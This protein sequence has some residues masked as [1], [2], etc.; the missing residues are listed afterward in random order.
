M[1]RTCPR[2]AIGSGKGP[3][4]AP[5]GAQTGISKSHAR[6]PRRDQG[7]DLISIARP[8]VDAARATGLPGPQHPTARVILER[9]LVSRQDAKT[10]SFSTR[11]LGRTANPPDGG[12][13]ACKVLFFFAFLASLREQFPIPGLSTRTR[14]MNLS[15]QGVYEH[16][17][18]ESVLHE[19]PAD[20]LRELPGELIVAVAM[21]IKA[22][23]MPERANGAGRDRVS[24][25]A[26]GGAP[27]QRCRTS[28]GAVGRAH[29]DVGDC[30]RL[31]WE[32]AGKA[33]AHPIPP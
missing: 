32:P 3:E 6:M 24:D 28:P 18:A 33:A 31:L 19:L 11:D 7:P 14:L 26:G 27:P 13:I 10:Q 15:R 16:P 4:P 17:L 8:M 2:S 22:C 30:D 1:A 12:I 29:V 21:A 5:A 23:A 20:W 9:A 25:G